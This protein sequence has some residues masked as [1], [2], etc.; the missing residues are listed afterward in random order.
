MDLDY[1]K[2]P[3]GVQPPCTI[4]WYITRYYEIEHAKIRYAKAS[5]DIPDEWSKEQNLLKEIMELP[6]TIRGNSN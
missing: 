2:P 6:L 4:Q 1:N 3:L 5:I